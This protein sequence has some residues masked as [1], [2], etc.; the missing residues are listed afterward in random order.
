MVCVGNLTHTPIPINS[1]DILFNSKIVSGLILF[2]WLTKITPEE[3]HHWKK[4]VSD[5]LRDGGKIF[6]TQVVKTVKLEDWEASL[7]EASQIA[8]QGKILIEFN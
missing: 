2:K 6:G 5:D 1:G 3:S 8:S 4:K 7:K